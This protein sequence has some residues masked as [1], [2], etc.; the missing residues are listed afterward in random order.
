MSKTIGS[1]IIFV[2]ATLVGLFVPEYSDAGALTTG[3]FNLI[4]LVAMITA[5]TEGTKTVIKYDSGTQ[6]KWI[7]KGI[8]V[9]WSL[10]FSLIGFYLN[11]GF[12]GEFFTEWYQ[13]AITSVIISGVARDFYNIEVAWKLVK[14]LFNKELPKV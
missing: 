14:F 7:P 12:Y 5:F 13:A 9:A 2:I 1:A 3:F 8:T 6:S 10:I 4:A 11:V